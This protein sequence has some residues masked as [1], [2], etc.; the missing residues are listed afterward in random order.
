MYQ[1]KGDVQKAL[2]DLDEALKLKPTLLEP[3]VQKA[4]IH[5]QQRKFDAAI[6]DLNRAWTM[7]K[8]N[9]ACCFCGRKCIRKRGTSKRPR[10]IW[11]K[12]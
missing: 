10:P 9:V 3:L 8:G 4:R 11:T 12:P 6:D 5:V 2:A 7:S 1:E